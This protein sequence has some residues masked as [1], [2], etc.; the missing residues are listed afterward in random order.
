M[1]NAMI[2]CL[3]LQPVSNTKSDKETRD[4][5]DAYMTSYNKKNKSLNTKPHMTPISEDK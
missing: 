4:V 1:G 5:I 2:K 3:C